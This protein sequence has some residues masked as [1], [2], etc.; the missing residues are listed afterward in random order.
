[1]LAL[2]RR[3]NVLL[4]LQREKSASVSELS[5]YYKVSDETIRRDLDKL[6][7]EG[8]IIKSYGGA[9][10]KEPA[11]SEVSEVS[12]ESKADAP[13]MLRKSDNA[14]AKAV[15]ADLVADLIED[16]DHIILDASTTSI[17]VETGLK[18]KRNLTVVT[19]SIE[20]LFNQPEGMDWEVI[21]TGGYFMDEYKALVGP[22]AMETVNTFNSDKVILS[23]KCIDMKKGITDSNEMFA[24]VKR[25]MVSSAYETIL[26]VDHTKFGQVGF[27][28]ICSFEQVDTIVTDI[29]PEDRWMDFFADKGIRV[30]YPED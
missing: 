4:R 16:G 3:Q 10:L 26:A 7:K 30:I 21:S 14:E 23:C 5:S 25:S 28:R 13:F 8:Y 22:R 15:I 29:R 24:M 1:M 12:H 20:V 19:N 11:A 27:F 2:E 17:A 6:E 9:T 18:N